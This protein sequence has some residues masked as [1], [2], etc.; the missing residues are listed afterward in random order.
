MRTILIAVPLLREYDN[1][2]HDYRGTIISYQDAPRLCRQQYTL[3]RV[4]SRRGGLMRFGNGPLARRKRHGQTLLS[5]RISVFQ[6]DAALV[7]KAVKPLDIS[8]YGTV[9]VS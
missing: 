1:T 2:I 4:H 9:C 5:A 7:A 8:N 3:C 6:I